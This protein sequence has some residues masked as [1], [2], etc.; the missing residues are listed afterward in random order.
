MGRLLIRS[1]LILAAFGLSLAAF[2]YWTA[3]RDPIVR[4]TD[5]VLP[6]WPA[7]ASPVRALLLTDL[8]VAG[9]DMPPARLAR[10]VEQANA[11]RPD[12]VLIAGDFVS[13]K[14]T[15]THFYGVT[16][17]VAPLARLRA[18]LG[19]VAVLGNHDH[20]RDAE[21]MRRALR[22]AGVTVLDNDA[23]AR[24]PLAI[25]GLDDDFTAHA[26]LPDTVAA[27]RRVPG[28]RLLL[29]HSPDPFPDMPDDV[30]LMLAGHTHCGQIRLPWVGAITT[31]SRYDQRYACGRIDERGRTLIVSAG[32]GTSVLPLRLGASPDLWLLTLRPDRAP[33][34]RR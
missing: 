23:V 16:E 19:T 9:P 15:A 20:W 6:G 33:A 27:L 17:A 8:H 12:L 22:A 28:A 3:I 4:E 24:G 11:L 25:G 18:P 2:A 30:W 7:G 14:R 26:D 5:V 31:M 13:D 21:Q 32:L 34:P 29:S 1:V 10:I